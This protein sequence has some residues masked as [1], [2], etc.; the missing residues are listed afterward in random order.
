MAKFPEGLA[1]AIAATRRSIKNITH[2]TSIEGFRSIIENNQLWAS[3]IRFLNDKREMDFGLEAAVAFLRE[4]DEN[5]GGSSVK[6]SAIKE[7]SARIRARGIPSAYACCF[8]TR[9]DNLSQ[10]RGYS[11]G[12]QGISIVFEIGKLEQH[13]KSYGAIIAEVAYGADATK[14]RLKEEFEKYVTSTSGDLFSYGTLSASD[15]E[16]LILSLS[17]QFK[18]KSFEDEREW[19]VIVNG[20]QKT[21]DLCYR[22]KDNVLVPYIRLGEPNLPLPI[23]QVIIGPGKDMD[24]TLQSVELFLK[25]KLEYE[26]VEVIKSTVPFRT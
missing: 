1:K 12:G 24:I 20:P 19:R 15:L 4:Q 16:N 5:A 22:T 23:E 13:F 9:R 11:T 10:W 21:G 8:C 2:Y 14:R 25:S 26:D 17:P 18:H 3:N 6:N 7:A